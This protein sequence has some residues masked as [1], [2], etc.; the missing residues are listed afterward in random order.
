MTKVEKFSIKLLAQTCSQSE[1]II[2]L[3]SKSWPRTQFAT[4]YLEFPKHN[5]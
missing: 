3:G 2:L 5:E 4:C 1:F